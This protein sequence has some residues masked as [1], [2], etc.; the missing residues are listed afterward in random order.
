MGDI[1]ML[2]AY[3][4]LQLYIILTPMKVIEYHNNV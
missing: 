1:V 2:I 4:I 3:F